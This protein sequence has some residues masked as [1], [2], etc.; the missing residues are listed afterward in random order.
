MD[1]MLATMCH[2]LVL[3]L[4]RKVEAAVLE[5]GDPPNVVMVSDIQ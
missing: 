1:A 4:H 3:R 2:N 5:K